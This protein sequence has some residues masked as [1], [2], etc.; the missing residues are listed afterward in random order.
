MEI[1]Q[2]WPQEKLFFIASCALFPDKV[3]SSPIKPDFLSVELSVEDEKL[4]ELKSYAS[5]GMLKFIIDK[6]DNNKTQYTI[7]SVDQAKF[8]TMMVE[9]LKKFRNDELLTSPYKKP[10]SFGALRDRLV[11]YLLHSERSIPL[12]NAYNIWP[13]WL[14]YGSV[15]PFWEIILSP[16]MLSGDI[17]VHNIGHSSID[18]INGSI[19]VPFAEIEVINKKYLQ[20]NANLHEV[21][22]FKANLA[23]EDKS[24]SKHNLIVEIENHGSYYIKKSLKTDLAPHLLMSHLL[25][26]R[27]KKF[28]IKQVRERIEGL[29]KVKNLSEI[30]RQ[31]GFSEE[32][33]AIFFDITTN[34]SVQ[35]KKDVYLHESEIDFLKNNH[36][37]VSERQ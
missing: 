1:N 12:I 22:R 26:N 30:L 27:G 25:S 21:G 36:R 5:K 9:Y 18:D 13:N 4:K 7:S 20:N 11:Q 35:L 28:S 37:S 2:Y 33:K 29:D 16:A 14:G 23:I 19:S 24:S 15:Y 8:H 6:D 32:L 17:K 10:E 3:I 34:T 31:C